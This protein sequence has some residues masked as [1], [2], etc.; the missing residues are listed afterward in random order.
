MVQSMGEKG[1]RER[2]KRRK[3]DG[4]GPSDHREKREKKRK[5][6]EYGGAERTSREGVGVFFFYLLWGEFLYSVLVYLWRKGKR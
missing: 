1:G 4:V 2:V 6:R 5:K 3:G